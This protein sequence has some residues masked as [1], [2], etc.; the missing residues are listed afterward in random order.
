MFFLGNISS[1]I[2]KEKI[3]EELQKE[4]T[5]S[6]SHCDIPP[7]KEKLNAEINRRFADPRLPRTESISKFLLIRINDD[8]NIIGVFI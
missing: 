7:V 5:V 3:I 2:T 4:G 1:E 8:L 6:L